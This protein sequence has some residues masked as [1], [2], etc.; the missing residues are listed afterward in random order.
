MVEDSQ[1]YNNESKVNWLEGD[2]LWSM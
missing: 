2:C 1:V